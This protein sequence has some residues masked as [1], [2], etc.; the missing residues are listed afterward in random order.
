MFINAF[1]LLFFL[2]L[3]MKWIRLQ[4][5]VKLLLKVMHYNIALLPKKVTNYEEVTSLQVTKDEEEHDCVATLGRVWS[6]PDLKEIPLENA[7]N[8]ICRWFSI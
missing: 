2:L 8:S 5:W 1:L 7:D 6:G 4:C 3:H